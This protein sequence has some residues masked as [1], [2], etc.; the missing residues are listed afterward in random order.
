MPLELPAELSSGIPP[1]VMSDPNISRYND[2]PSLMKGHIELNKYAGRSV[3]LPAEDAKPED[4]TKWKSEHLGKFSKVLDLPPTTANDYEFKVEGIDDETIKS[5]KIMGLY[6]DT[7]HKL[8]L[9]KSQAAGLYESFAR[10]IMPALM[11]QGGPQIEFID[12][13]ED[14]QTVI[15]ETFKAETPL[16]MEEFH[17]GVEILNSLR[18][19]FKDFLHEGTSPLGKKWMANGDHPMMVWLV[20]EFGRMNGQDFGGGV[21]HNKQAVMDAQS[22]IARLMADETWIK[23]LKANDK[24]AKAHMSELWAATTGGR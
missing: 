1:E 20:T 4:L 2:L 17:R 18:P 16:R 13:P 8:G 10:D 6:R 15:Q 11:P 9:S 12:K 22:E 7:A 21:E 5:D 3:A 23:R 24:E 14:V 19:G